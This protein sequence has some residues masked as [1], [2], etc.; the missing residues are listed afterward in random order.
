MCAVQSAK[1]ADDRGYPDDRRRIQ[2]RAAEPGDRRPVRRLHRAAFGTDEGEQISAV[3]AQLLD[4]DGDMV[5][6]WVAVS[7]DRVVG[8]VAFSRVTFAGEAAL[9]GAL[10]APLGVTP[11]VQGMGVGTALVAHGVENLK[12]RDVDLV[13]VYGDPSYYGRFGFR[14]EPAKRYQA[15]QPLQHPVGWQALALSGRDANAAP[16]KLICH[17]AFDDPALW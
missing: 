8:H 10:L 7:G 13:F 1:H 15:P 2:V 4:D 11:G 17:P 12:T 9:R 16:R 3:V 6:N 14:A 5:A